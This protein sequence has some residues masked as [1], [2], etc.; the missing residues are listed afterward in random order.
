MEGIYQRSMQ[1][2]RNINVNEE[3]KKRTNVKDLIFKKFKKDDERENDISKRKPIND[4][5]DQRSDVKL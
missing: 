1:K 3:I 5:C 4:V 2:L